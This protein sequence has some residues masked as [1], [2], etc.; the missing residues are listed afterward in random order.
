ML[1]EIENLKKGNF[2]D[3]LVTS[4]INNLKKK[5]YTSPPKL[6]VEGPII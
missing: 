2:D 1:G 6:I 5:C 3:N 4:I